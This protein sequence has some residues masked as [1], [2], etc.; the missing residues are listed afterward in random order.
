MS[1]RDQEAAPRQ[2]AVFGQPKVLARVGGLWVL[3]KPAG[4]ATHPTGEGG[5][6]LMTWAVANLGA[7]KGLSPIHRLD[8]ESSGV[9]M[10]AGDAKILARYGQLFERG[11]VVKRYLAVVIGRAHVKGI[12]RR[13]L[14]EGNHGGMVEATTRYRKLAWYGPTTYLEVRPETGRK[15]QIRRH[16]H[17]IGHPIV[18]DERYPPTRF[19][20]VPGF[21]GRLWLHAASVELPGAVKYEAP[22]PPEL[23]AHLE[24]LAALED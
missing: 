24:V 12:I 19:R 16:L 9:V 17:G 20:A 23:K 22:L 2:Y 3:S 4:F 5:Q 6:D 21:P 10:C 7:P 11:K 8:R 1:D 15:H 18:G 13:P 14:K